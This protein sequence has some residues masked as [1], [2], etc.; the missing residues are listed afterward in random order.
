MSSFKREKLT[1][2][3]V[4]GVHTT[5]P[6]IPRRYTLT[7][8]DRTGDLFLTIGMTYAWHNLN[9]MRDEVL[10]EWRQ[11]RG[12]LY[13][14][15]HVYI[16]QGE[17]DFHKAAMRNEVFRRELPLAI[18]AIRYGD[19]KFFRTHPSLDLAPIFI[20]FIS[21]YIPLSKQEYWGTFQQF[22]D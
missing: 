13:Y 8:S 3:F 2:E 5:E 21:S 11:A 18:T 22:S 7:H 19:R 20:T 10:G 12:C 6:V 14:G 16:D 4:D 9:P 1:V 15:I 17:Y